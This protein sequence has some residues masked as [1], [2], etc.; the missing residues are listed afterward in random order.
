M[1][2]TQLL[3]EPTAFKTM[4]ESVASGTARLFPGYA[5]ADDVTQELWIWAF[6]N[7]DTV[8]RYD[9]EEDGERKLAFVL[10]QKAITYCN[11]EKAARLGYSPDDVVG[12]G[13]KQL[14]I[15]L[16]DVFEYEDWQSG[17]VSYDPTPKAKRIEATDDRLASMADVKSGLERLDERHYN[18][19]VAKYKYH[20]SDE[21]L[22]DLMEIGLSSVAT[23]LNR[24]VRALSRLLS[25]PVQPDA[26]QGRHV[27]S[28]A[29]ARAALSN[30]YEG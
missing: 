30:Q 17:A 1:E 20:Y 23:T 14:K 7:Q 27:V 8:R 3:M 25:T 2:G 26:P 19:L 18:M 24:S 9:E 13:V 28:N 4:L 6:E 16:Q 29:A 15:L 10:K 11:G 22:A 5:T 12:Y 21:R